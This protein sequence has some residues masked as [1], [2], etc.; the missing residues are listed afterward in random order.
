[1][2]KAIDIKIFLQKAETL[3]VIDVRTTKEFENGHIPGAHNIPLFTVEERASVGTVYKRKGKDKS[4]LTGL[5]LVGPKLVQYIKKL[6]AIT[7]KKEVLIYC[8]RGGMRSS[9][10]A[11]LFETI[12]YKTF[13]LSGGY[14]SYRRHIHKRFEEKSNIIILGGMTGSGKTDILNQL[15]NL[16]EQVID[17]ERLANHKGS[18][19][20]AIGEE[21]QPSTEQFENNLY[22]E[23][24]KFH[25]KSVIWI[26]DESHLIG[27][28]NIPESLWKQMRRSP[29]IKI[30]ISKDI[31]IKR[32]VKIYAHYN[33][34]LLESAIQKIR[35]RLGGQNLKAALEAIRVKDYQTAASI[36]L[37][38][39]DKAYLHGL[40]KRPKEDIF[41][42]KL[43]M[44]N[45][46]KNA[47]IIK[48]FYYD[49][50]CH[51]NRI[52]QP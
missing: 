31:R 7:E 20:G 24:K 51:T 45:P 52:V 9:S 34:D 21:K 39:Y 22:E 36:S 28:D 19:F 37:N 49:Q 30:D 38:Y 16:G 47:E 14:K 5:K 43:E 10:L 18:A 40:S 6:K 17:L 11:W 50:V 26:E 32:L 48:S 2:S 41:T 33:N 25:K 42:L 27:K 29:V 12:D 13:T 3:P 15:S 44:D 4:V 8:W 1:M 23:L 35:K 46:Q